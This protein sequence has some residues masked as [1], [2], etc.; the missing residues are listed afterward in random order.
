[1]VSRYS[2]FMVLTFEVLNSDQSMV[3][4]IVLSPEVLHRVFSGVYSMMVL[5]T[6][7]S[8]SWLCVSVLLFYQTFFSRIASWV[9]NLA[10]AL[11]SQVV[12]HSGIYHY[13][14]SFLST[15]SILLYL[16]IFLSFPNA[17]DIGGSPGTSCLRPH[18]PL[19]FLFGNPTALGNQ[20]TSNWANSEP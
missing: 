7:I 1:M 10:C 8:W 9:Y 15:A 12:I 11:R 17:Q 18:S 20:N 2:L 19:P 6:C 14:A 16:H 3:S 13:V 4:F 5:D